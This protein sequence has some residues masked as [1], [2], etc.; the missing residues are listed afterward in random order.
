VVTIPQRSAAVLIVSQFGRSR[1]FVHAVELR[2]IH[3]GDEAFMRPFT[4]T[5]WK[6]TYHRCHHLLQLVAGVERRVSF[7]VAVLD[8]PAL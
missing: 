5:F 3:G 7:C 2:S 1:F 8:A 4:N 6:E